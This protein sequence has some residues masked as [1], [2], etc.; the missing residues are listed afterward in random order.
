MAKPLTEKQKEA[1][2]RGRAIANS[3][4]AERGAEHRAARAAETPDVPPAPPGGA[5]LGVH[6]TPPADTAPK[7]SRGGRP[8]GY[9]P[10]AAGLRQVR[11][12]LVSLFT[13]TGVGLSMLDPFDG[14][15]VALNAERLADAW[16][17]LA[18]QDARVRRAL[19]AMLAGSA[20]GTAITTTAMV[21]LPIAA[22]HR[23]APPEVGML[24]TQAGIAVPEVV[25]PPEVR[26]ERRPQGAPMAPQGDPTMAP[27]APSAAPPETAP[28]PPSDEVAGWAAN[29]D[30]P[31]IDAGG[32]LF[33]QSPQPPAGG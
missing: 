20:W 15:V 4:R 23:L 30:V 32:V 13:M 7:G 27:H 1:L 33:P 22:H 12:G 14:Q 16:T 5:D 9:S 17:Q 2:A 18:E 21:A 26:V 31:P 28:V 19:E 11:A 3:K 8:A 29:G 24:A 10:K 25:A 6:E